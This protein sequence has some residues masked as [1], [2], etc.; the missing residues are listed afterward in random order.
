[1]YAWKTLPSLSLL[2]VSA[3]LLVASCAQ[4]DAV[5]TSS[6]EPSSGADV[7]PGPGTPSIDPDGPDGYG[8][9]NEY[10]QCL[11]RCDLAH[12]YCTRG[13]GGPSRPQNPAL[14]ARR[15]AACRFGC[16]EYFRL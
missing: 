10:R 6:A 4:P 1:M 3:G 13:I 9:L 16:Y 2:L 12:I 7:V 15:R 14:C 5:A 11:S 8:D